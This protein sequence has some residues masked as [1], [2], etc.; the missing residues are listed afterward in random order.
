MARTEHFH[1]A[2]LRI[3]AQRTDSGWAFTAWRPHT[4]QCFTDSAS[5]LRWA[6]WPAKTPTG[7]ALRQ[8][9]AGLEAV[10]APAPEPV[11]HAAAPGSFDPLAHLDESD[12]NHQTRAI[13]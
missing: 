4:S 13:T 8:W 5:L 9:I 2:T 11:A 10:T 12:P 7:D 1:A 3:E 6:K